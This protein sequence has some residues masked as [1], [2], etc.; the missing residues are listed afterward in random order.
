MP[1]TLDRAKSLRNLPN[2]LTTVRLALAFVL[3]GVIWFDQWLAALVVFV[4]AAITDWLDGYFARKA[5]LVSSLG[6]VYDPLVDKV[7]TGGAFIFLMEEPQAGF[8]AWMVTIIIARE[9]IVTGLR[10]FLE[11]HGVSF[12]ADR[13]GKLKMLLQCVAIGWVFL[14]LHLVQGTPDSSYPAVLVGVR[15]L[16]NWSTVAVTFLS[17]FNY[18]AGAIKHLT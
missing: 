18:V 10:G 2:Q 1:L 4:A 7:L 16:L 6:R 3:F 14:F 9:F 5:G 17:G 15:D 8:N 13:L 11:E 12:G